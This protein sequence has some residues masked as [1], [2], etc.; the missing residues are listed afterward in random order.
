MVPTQLTFNQHVEEGTRGQLKLVN[1]SLLPQC[2]G[3]RV[4]FRHAAGDCQ[5]LTWLEREKER[6]GAF[7][8]SIPLSCRTLV[9]TKRTMC[10]R[11]Q[12]LTSVQ[13]PKES[14][15]ERHRAQIEASRGTLEVR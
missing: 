13:T 11:L 1:R 6:T 9:A 2:F 4:S 3:R 8:F 15:E 7:G 5:Q 12:W 10:Q 14:A